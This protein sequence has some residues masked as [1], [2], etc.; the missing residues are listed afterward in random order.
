LFRQNVGVR[1]YTPA[2]AAMPPSTDLCRL[3]G[4][5]AVRG[6]VAH[7][8]YTTTRSPS[9][10]HRISELWISMATG[11]IL[12]RFEVYQGAEVTLMYNYDS[13]ITASIF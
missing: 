6:K 9:T 5:E 7:H 8:Y 10:D 3:V 13:G 1:S 12:K 2:E 4:L 11:Q